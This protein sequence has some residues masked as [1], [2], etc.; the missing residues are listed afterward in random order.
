MPSLQILVSETEWRSEHCALLSRGAV[1][2]CRNSANRAPGFALF[3]GGKP[4]HWEEALV[5]VAR[6]LQI[7]NVSRHIFYK[8]DL[9]I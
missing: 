5:T 6:L 8:Q 1:C 2:V 4:H 7:R 3:G 9:T